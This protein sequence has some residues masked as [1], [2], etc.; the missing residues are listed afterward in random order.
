M[1]GAGSAEESVILQRHAQGCVEPSR[2]LEDPIVPLSVPTGVQLSPTSPKLVEGR[3]SEL[4][5]AGVLGSSLAATTPS[6]QYNCA[7]GAA[8]Y[9]DA[10]NVVD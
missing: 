5:L 9:E 6:G 8:D 4:R 1:S 7:F 10:K 3:F 2:G